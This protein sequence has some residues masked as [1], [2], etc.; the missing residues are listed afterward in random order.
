MRSASSRSTELVLGRLPPAAAA[1][2]R[3]V[4]RAGG[5]AAGLVLVGGAVRDALLGR[6]VADL[7]VALP[8]GAL[9]LAER[10]AASLGATAVVLDAER[11]AA[12]VA[13]P[14]LQ[15]DINDFRAPDL[16]GDLAA[17]DFT[18]NALA[19]PLAPLL[20]AGRA[21]IVDPTGG[22][23]DLRARRLRPAGPGVL[24][25]DPLRALRAVRLEAT[26]GL[27][28]TPAG[29]R[30]VRSV[31]PALARVSAERVRDEV[32]ALLAL[33]ATGRALRRADRLGVLEAVLP[34]VAPMRR[35]PQPAPHRFDVLEHSLRAVEAC[36]RLLA[37]LDALEPFGEEL[38]AH[39][40]ERLGGALD[41]RRVLK[42]AALLHDVSKP[43]TRAVV[44]GHVHFYQHDVIGARRARAIGDRL[45]L[46]ERAI[47]VLERLVRQHL[48]PMHLGQAGEVTRRA[49]YRF[50]RDLGP[51]TRDLLLL[52][53]VDAAAVTGVTPLAIWRRAGLVRDLM[54][55]WAE[56]ESVAA[57]PP[58]V[59]GED[60]MTRFALPPGPA[61]GDLLARAR[62]AQDLGVV[63]TRE[64]ALAYLDSL[65]G[66]P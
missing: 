18:V 14:G 22:R 10:V 7:D 63:R 54:T 12:R 40:D 60:V 45:R 20:T 21:P 6:P 65:G 4:R 49:R 16:A 56:A 8:T 1:V 52:S 37:R 29:A 34:E 3:A 30:A 23:D 17:R 13:G 5:A 41:R 31:A 35:S 39:V 53:L 15:L 42:L 66:G 19:V 64:E 27:T 28:L 32:V 57:A 51:D 33:P 38:A 2:L 59:R 11:G 50:Y 26:L 44:D 55:G 36:D 62:E 43:E 47:A 9:A 24:A 25:D 48:R 46:P 58:L 61:V